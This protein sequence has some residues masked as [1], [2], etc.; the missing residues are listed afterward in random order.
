MLKPDDGSE[1]R[2]ESVSDAGTVLDKT[3]LGSLLAVCSREVA[4]MVAAAG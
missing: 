2:K 3:V 4:D 1:E